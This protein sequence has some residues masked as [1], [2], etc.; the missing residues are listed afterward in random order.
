[1][2]PTLIDISKR[3]HSKEYYDR[4]R[5]M[6]TALAWNAVK[7]VLHEHHREELF[8]PI[9]SIRLTEKALIITTLKPV[10]NAE[11]KMYAEKILS[12]F[13]ESMRTFGGSQR[14]EIKLR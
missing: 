12:K 8:S 11:I 10:V 3:E 9:Q 5:D 14:K 2:K 1:M 6:A 7:K 13:Q 4:S